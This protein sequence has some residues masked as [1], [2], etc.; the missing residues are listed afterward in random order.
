MGDDGRGR[1]AISAALHGDLPSDSGLA[2][3][4]ALR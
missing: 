2:T 4:R 1:E 3:G